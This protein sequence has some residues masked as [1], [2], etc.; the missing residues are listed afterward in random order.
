MFLFVSYCM[1]FCVVT[2][3]SSGLGKAVALQLLKKGANVFIIARNKEQLRE[4]VESLRLEKIFDDQIIEAISA[5]VTNFQNI[6]E[7]VKEIEVNHGKIEVLFSCAGI[8]VHH[9]PLFL[10]DF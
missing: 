5:N 7:A 1:Q 10:S 2:G 6:R 4:T 9:I 3:G 8:K